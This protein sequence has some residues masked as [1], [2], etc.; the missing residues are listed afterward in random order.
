M[1]EQQDQGR[2]N[3][4]R[5]HIPIIVGLH[6]GLALSPYLFSVVLGELTSHSQDG[7]LRFLWFMLFAEFL[8]CMLFADGLVL[9]ETRDSTYKDKQKL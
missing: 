8:G 6:Q 5:H 2:N 9:V 3:W 7:I 1:I 4:V